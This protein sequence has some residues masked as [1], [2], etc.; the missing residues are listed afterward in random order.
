MF[1][2]I[3]L[4]G[5]E[6]IDRYSH[7]RA[8]RLCPEAPVPVLVRNVTECYESAGGA[9]LV[10]DNLIAFGFDVHCIFGSRSVKERFFA[11]GHM[12]CRV[13]S[14]G[15]AVRDTSREIQSALPK[16]NAIVI[17]DYC[18]GAVNWAAAKLAV[19]SGL[20]CF[21]DTKNSHIEWYRG[22]NVTLFPNEHEYTSHVKGKEHLFGT[23]IAKKGAAG[24]AIWN[25]NHNGTLIPVRQREARDVCGAGDSFLAAYL[26]ASCNGLD[27]IA[28]AKVANEAAG[29]SVEHIGTYIFH[30]EDIERL[31]S[32]GDIH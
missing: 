9:G 22:E 24:C 5:D 21:V 10:R 23:V 2:K 1:P 8:E 4:I 31:R 29:I 15:E 11:G 6:I 26:W 27:T 7:C 18:K 32:L 28:A 17:S 16:V 14:D 19:S 3:L 12:V 30:P 25:D 13:D 20:P